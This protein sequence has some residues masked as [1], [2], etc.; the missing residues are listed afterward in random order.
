MALRFDQVTHTPRSR[1]EKQT[2]I[3]LRGWGPWHESELSE[4][5]QH[6][7]RATFSVTNEHCKKCQVLRPALGLGLSKAHFVLA[8]LS[9]APSSHSL[10]S[11]P[12]T[13]PSP[14]INSCY[15]PSLTSSTI[16]PFSFSSL[17]MFPTLRCAHRPAFALLFP[18][19]RPEEVI[20]LLNIF[21][22]AQRCVL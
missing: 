13:P 3:G 15:C 7:S 11:L 6:K 1:Q 17:S 8:F 21:W 5:S 18:R 14:N 19:C 10:P 12:P 20:T 4:A 2:K 22:H 16:T 9:H